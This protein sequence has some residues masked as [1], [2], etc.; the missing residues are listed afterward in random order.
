MALIAYHHQGSASKA[1]CTLDTLVACEVS[2]QKKYWRHKGDNILYLPSSRWHSKNYQE[3]TTNSEK[4]TPRREQ[5]VGS[6]DLSG[7]LQGEPEGLQPTRIT[8]WRWSQERLWVHSRWFHLSSSQW[9]TSSIPCA[10]GRNIP[11]SIEIH[12]CNN[13]NSHWSWRHARETYWWLL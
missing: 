2:M 8:R 9:T 6:E 13:V 10:E 4:P 5:P 7:E 12:W 11:Y 1:H 3:K